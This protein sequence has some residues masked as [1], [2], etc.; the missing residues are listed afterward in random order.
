MYKIALLSTVLIL[1]AWVYPPLGLLGPFINFLSWLSNVKL[2]LL[3]IG[4]TLLSF[5]AVPKQSM[6][7][8]IANL[9]GITA[10][11]YLYY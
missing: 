1:V 6:L 8:L 3:N 4:L 2:T 5:I 9:G 11:I 10:G 7:L